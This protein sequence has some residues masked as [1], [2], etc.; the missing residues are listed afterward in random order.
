MSLSALADS[1]VSGTVKFS[2]TSSI[3]TNAIN[4]A[5]T[6]LPT[7]LSS[8]NP[9]LT[10]VGGTAAPGTYNGVVVTATDADGAVLHG[11]FN[12]TVEANAVSNYGN[13]VNRFGNGFD[14]FRQHQYPG[15]IIAGWPA[16]Q[17][18]RRRT[19]CSPTARTRVPSGSSTPPT[20]RGPG[21]ACPIPAVAGPLTRCA[22]A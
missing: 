18:T 8:G 15:A 5:E 1:N 21:S 14:A 2:A 4:F 10:Y 17:S 11:T 7:G 13:E 12:L 19:S 20:A 16:T 22:T 9:V 3:S 6:N